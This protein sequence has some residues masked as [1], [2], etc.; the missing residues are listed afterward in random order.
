VAAPRRA[1]PHPRRHRDVLCISRV[2]YAAFA[3]FTSTDLQKYNR[4]CSLVWG[5]GNIQI[6]PWEL[7]HP[8]ASASH[9]LPAPS[10]TEKRPPSASSSTHK[11]HVELE[12]GEFS[13]PPPVAHALPLTPH[14]PPADVPS[15]PALL[16]ADGY[17]DTWDAP[18]PP[19]SPARPAS[20]LSRRPSPAAPYAVPLGPR[21]RI[22][23]PERVVLD[24]RIRAVH[25]R[26]M[27]EVVLGGSAIGAVLTVVVLVLPV[28]R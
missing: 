17:R 19:L 22:F 4:F 12:P 1:V 15:S 2:R 14:T 3:T 26:V 5:R 25:A 8:P 27:R 11:T 10:N 7:A 9:A 21:A 13:A 6:R 28:C 18:P 16:L 23:G 24:P 20:V